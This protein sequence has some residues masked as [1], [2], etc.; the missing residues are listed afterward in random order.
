MVANQ[1]G[2]QTTK[3]NEYIIQKKKAGYGDQNEEGIEIISKNEKKKLGIT[4]FKL[5][6]HIEHTDYGNSLE[7]ELALVII[8]E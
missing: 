2:K 3:S 7:V 6:R 1:R 8:Y 4:K 5:D